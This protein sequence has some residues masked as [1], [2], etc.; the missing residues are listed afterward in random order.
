MYREV[1][2]SHTVVTRMAPGR[3]AEGPLMLCSS[4]AAQGITCSASVHRAC[5]VCLAGGSVRGGHA[6]RDT[7]RSRSRTVDAPQSPR[8]PAVQRAPCAALRAFS[9][10]RCGIRLLDGLNEARRWCRGG[11]GRKRILYHTC[12]AHTT[13]DTAPHRCIPRAAAVIS[14]WGLSVSRPLGSWRSLASR[15]QTLGLAL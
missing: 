11:G 8:A 6:E 10:I 15:N 13:R 4:L 14:T 5:T 3:P 9:Q 1:R 7:S 2:P 12:L